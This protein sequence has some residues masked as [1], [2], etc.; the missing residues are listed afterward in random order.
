MRNRTEPH[1]AGSEDWVAGT[2]GDCKVLAAFYR[3]R[4]FRD[5]WSGPPEE[6]GWLEQ[7]RVGEILCFVKA[8]V[9]FST[10][11]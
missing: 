11:S 10:T 8:Y 9:E 3:G 2:H 5:A 1:P 6:V 4:R 7:L